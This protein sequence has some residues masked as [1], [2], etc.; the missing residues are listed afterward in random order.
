MYTRNTKKKIQHYKIVSYVRADKLVTLFLQ[1]I[2]VWSAT[3]A[4]KIFKTTLIYKLDTNPMCKFLKK[5]NNLCVFLYKHIL[6][7]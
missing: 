6:I 2:R 7:C 5:V 4:D 3:V 1:D